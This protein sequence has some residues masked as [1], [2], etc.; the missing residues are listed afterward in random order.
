LPP[1]KVG[2]N[3]IESLEIRENTKKNR[4]VCEEI[5][6]LHQVAIYYGKKLEQEEESY[7]S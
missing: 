3:S 2:R 4:V 1:I 5:E 7:V 6:T